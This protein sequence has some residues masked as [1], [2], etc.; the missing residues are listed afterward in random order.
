MEISRLL[1]VTF[2]VR[3]TCAYK[4]CWYY[5]KHA[6]TFNNTT[7]TATDT[8]RRTSRSG[9]DK[10]IYTIRISEKMTTAPCMVWVCGRSLMGY[11]VKIPLGTWM[12]VTCEYFVLSGGVLCDGPIIR[13]EESYRVCMCY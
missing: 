3:K 5:C 13:P 12:S 4:C 1:H 11:R 9:T 8:N 7:G 2:D 6:A 10:T